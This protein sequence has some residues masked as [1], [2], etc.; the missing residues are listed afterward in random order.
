MDATKSSLAWVAAAGLI[1][2]AASVSFAE[3]AP[4]SGLITPAMT[5]GWIERSPASLSLDVLPAHDRLARRAGPEIALARTEEGAVRS[6]EAAR[7]RSQ[8]ITLSE[9]VLFDTNR[10]RVKSS[11]K[12]RL[13]EVASSWH[14]HPHWATIHIE[15]HTDH[16]GPERYNLALSELRAARVL[17]ALIELGVPAAAL[18]S[19]GFGSSVPCDEAGT[20]D[21]LE[22]NR[23]VELVIEWAP[24][25][26]K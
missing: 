13:R 7:P 2:G 6:L 4:R 15:G 21:A 25:P 12:E 26:R 19:E 17:A 1:C 9:R 22:R 23:R 5:P 24:A 11:G 18:S 14:T 3:P 20:A 8:R 16:T 10:A